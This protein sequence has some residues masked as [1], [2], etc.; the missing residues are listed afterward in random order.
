[1]EKDARVGRDVRM[2]KRSV[3]GSECRVGNKATIGNDGRVQPETTILENERVGTGWV[4]DDQA[5]AIWRRRQKAAAKNA[6][7]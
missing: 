1:M 2:G 7:K 6:E 4:V 5:M 3:V